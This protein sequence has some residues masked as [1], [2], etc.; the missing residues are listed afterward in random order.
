MYI[1]IEEIKKGDGS[2]IGVGGSSIDNEERDLINLGAKDGKLST[3]GG[4]GEANVA[5]G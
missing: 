5:R 4:E 2:Y 3:T 1:K